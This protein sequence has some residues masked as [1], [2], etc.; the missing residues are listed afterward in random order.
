MKIL[1]TGAAGFIGYHLIE[2]LLSHEHEII[3]LDNLNAYYDTT[4]K[5]DRI[6]NLGISK[7]VHLKEDYAYF[8]KNKFTF[9]KTDITNTLFINTLFSEYNF[10]VVIHLAA[11]AGVRYSITNPDE[12]IKSNINGFYTILSACKENKINHFIYASS[13]SVYGNTKKIPFSIEDETNEPISLYAA[14]K[15]SNELLAYSYSHLYNLKTTG[16]RDR[17]RHV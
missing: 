8:G 6:E 11:Q 17:K 10:E 3:G 9:F 14:S 15:K 5:R 4:L 13:S 12:Y 1:V 16:L 2:V 7:S